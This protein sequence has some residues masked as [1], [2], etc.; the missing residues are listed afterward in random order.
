MKPRIRP[1]L[2]V[3]PPATLLRKPTAAPTVTPAECIAVALTASEWKPGNIMD[4]E[5]NVVQLVLKSLKREGWKIVPME[6]GD[7]DHG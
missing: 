1:G 5:G 2:F 7:Y 3:D 6:K 4:P